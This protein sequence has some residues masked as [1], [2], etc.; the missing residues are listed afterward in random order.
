MRLPHDF[1]TERLTGSA[2]TDRGDASG[3]GWWSSHTG[4]YVA[5]VLA[6]VDLDLTFLPAVLAPDAIA[7][8]TAKADRLA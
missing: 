5:D 2:V 1:P 3:T 7:G 6:H 4:D 8:T